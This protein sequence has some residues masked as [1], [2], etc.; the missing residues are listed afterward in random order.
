MVLQSIHLYI[1]TSCVIL[2]IFCSSLFPVGDDCYL[3]DCENTKQLWDTD[4]IS[5]FSG[6]VAHKAHL[7]CHIQ[8]IAGRTQLIH[9]QYS[10]GIPDE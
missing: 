2:V 4:L 6:L 1:Y 10:K 8:S 3:S 7:Q 5:A 9:H